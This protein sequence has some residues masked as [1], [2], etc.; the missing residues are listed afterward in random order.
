MKYCRTWVCANLRYSLA[1]LFL[2]ANRILCGWKKESNDLFSANDCHSGWWHLH[3]GILSHKSQS[4]KM[5]KSPAK[6]QHRTN[7]NYYMSSTIYGDCR[8]NTQFNWI[9]FNVNEI[10]GESD[11]D[12]H[13]LRAYS[14]T[15]IQINDILLRKRHIL[16]IQTDLFFFSRL[17]LE[18]SHDHL[19]SINTC[20]STHGTPS[21]HHYLQQSIN[22][23]TIKSN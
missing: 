2:F 1:I 15:K 5:D 11:I 3:A 12:S 23:I 8:A 19:N 7:A 9:L 17:A 21:H 14:L 22:T 20:D 6:S 10:M 4:N 18:L 13:L 16:P